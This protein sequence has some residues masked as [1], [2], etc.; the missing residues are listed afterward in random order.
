[1]GK[2]LQRSHC[3]GCRD[4]HFRRFAAREDSITRAARNQRILM[5]MSK[6]MASRF[7]TC[8]YA[9]QL[10]PQSI[11]TSKSI[12]TCR[13]IVLQGAVGGVRGGGEGAR[14]RGGTAGRA[15]AFT[16]AAGAAGGPLDGG[17][18]GCRW[19]PQGRCRRLVRLPTSEL[20]L[21]IWLSSLLH[22]GINFLNGKLQQ[23]TTL[24]NCTG[25]LQF[26]RQAR[27]GLSAQ[28]LLRAIACVLCVSSVSAG[29]SP[30]TAGRSDR[31]GVGLL[32]AKRVP[33]LCWRVHSKANGILARDLQM[34]NSGSDYQLGPEGNA[35]TLC[36]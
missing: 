3:P 24:K 7:K 29:H 22:R 10:Y 11:S 16:G 2:D 14:R 8:S 19:P 35:S 21:S 4:S 36:H 34:Q 6:Q 5:M 1:M 15:R 33:L 9:A 27:M 18:G 31:F 30:R 20:S 12:S 23:Q 26:P 25:P 13:S 32:A 28:G 17:G